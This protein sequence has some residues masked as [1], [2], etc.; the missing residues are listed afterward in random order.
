MFLGRFLSVS[1]QTRSLHRY[2]NLRPVSQTS[3]QI[4]VQKS[5]FTLTI[6]TLKTDTISFELNSVNEDIMKLK[7]IGPV[8][9][10]RPLFLLNFSW[11]KISKIRRLRGR[12]V[13]GNFEKQRVTY[14]SEFYEVPSIM[15]SNTKLT[16]RVLL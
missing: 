9:E 16:S 2:R 13:T 8:L 7:Q 4:P 12:N 5:C 3:R 11:S 1:S 10:L 15:S 14:R 6:F